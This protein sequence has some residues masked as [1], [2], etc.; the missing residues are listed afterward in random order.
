MHFA[1]H[2]ALLNIILLGAFLHEL[3]ILDH[4]VGTTKS[5]KVL[6]PCIQNPENE[7]TYVMERIYLAT[8]PHNTRRVHF[9]DLNAGRAVTLQTL[10]Y[11]HCDPESGVL[12]ATTLE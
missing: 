11:L 4:D 1:L 12:S 5:V 8:N 6:L 2:G 3:E 9:L 10:S 7:C